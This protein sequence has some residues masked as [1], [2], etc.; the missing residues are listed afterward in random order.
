MEIRG[1]FGHGRSYGKRSCI[2]FRCLPGIAECGIWN[3]LARE[4]G[5][6]ELVVAADAGNDI[7]YGEDTTT[8]LR[9][10]E[11]CLNRVEADRRVIVGLPLAAIRGLAEPAFL[12]F[13]TLFFPPSRLTHAE[14]V[15]RTEDL[16][17][18]LRL[19]AEAVG[20]RFVEPDARWYHFDPIHI[21]PSRRIEAWSAI[22]GIDRPP[23]RRNYLEAARL[24]LAAPERRALFGVERR[25]EQPA[26]TL[27]DGIRLFLY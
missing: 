14:A 7:L 15:R 21:R 13:R 12:F 27:G 1:A 23:E 19:L 9:W 16:D 4:G 18:G 6:A 20:A 24:M 11:D 8:I 26:A 3:A 22:L 10:V 17:A 2:P 5:N 25:K